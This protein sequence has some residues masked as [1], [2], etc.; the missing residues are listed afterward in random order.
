MR[1]E[2]AYIHQVNFFYKF[3]IWLGGRCCPIKTKSLSRAVFEITGLER[4]WDDDLDLSQS[5]DVTIRSAIG[6]FLL[7]GIWY[8]VS[9]SNHFRDICI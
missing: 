5:H 6:H 9:V 7:V 3:Y 1:S 8:Q 2:S 4:Y